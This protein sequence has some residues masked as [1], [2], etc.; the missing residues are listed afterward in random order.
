MESFLNI[1]ALTTIVAGAFIVFVVFGLF[2]F[3]CIELV[4]E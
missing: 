4:K 2:V 1:I 3:I